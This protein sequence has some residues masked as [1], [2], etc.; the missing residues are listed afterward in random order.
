MPLRPTT[1]LVRS[2]RGGPIRIRWRLADDYMLHDGGGGASINN[3]MAMDEAGTFV[4]DGMQLHSL[5][6]VSHRKLLA[7]EPRSG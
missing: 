3:R 1:A 5:P 2:N 4:L 6:A 7:N